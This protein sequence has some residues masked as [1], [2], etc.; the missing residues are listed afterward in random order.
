MTSGTTN[1]SFEQ[2][3]GEEREKV[4]RSHAEEDKVIMSQELKE[5][6]MEGVDMKMVE[7]M[8]EE[9]HIRH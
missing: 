8:M 7:L 3:V 5:L 9:K 4:L 6:N 1:I 2:I